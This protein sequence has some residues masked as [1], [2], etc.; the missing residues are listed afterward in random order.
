MG[1]INYITQVQ[2]DFGAIRLAR[3]ECERSAIKRP[4]ICTDKGVVAAG[5]LDRLRE[6]L[7]DLPVTVFDGTPS[8]PTESAVMAAVDAY[9][10][11]RRA[12]GSAQE[13]RGGIDCPN[14]CRSRWTQPR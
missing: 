5:L 13:R 3:S 14:R 4:L 9:R 1:L 2:F 8:N 6:A 12:G 10:A 11:P 7:G